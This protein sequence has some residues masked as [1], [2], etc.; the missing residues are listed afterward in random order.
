MIVHGCQ[1]SHIFS[2]IVTPFRPFSAD[3][4]GAIPMIFIP[5]QPPSPKSLL[6]FYHHV[7]MSPIKPHPSSR[8]MLGCTLACKAVWRRWFAIR[9]FRHW[10]RR[11]RGGAWEIRRT[12]LMLTMSALLISA[13]GGSA[14]VWVYIRQGVGVVLVVGVQ[15]Y[16]FI[17]SL[18]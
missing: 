10:R 5:P 4:E 14:G 11:T 12:C 9:V 7:P 1:N 15:R 13:G 2:V 16:F 6:V 8:T 17:G 3:D 18:S